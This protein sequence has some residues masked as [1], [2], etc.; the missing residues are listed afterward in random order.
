MWCTDSAACI[1]SGDFCKA[2]V[3]QTDFCPVI[4]NITNIDAVGVGKNLTIILAARHLPQ[5]RCFWSYLF[6]IVILSS[7]LTVD[8]GAV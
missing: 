7:K 2:P 6:C 5:V 4:N 3:R 8:I 1:V